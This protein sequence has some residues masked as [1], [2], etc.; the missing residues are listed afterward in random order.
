[1]SLVPRAR[2]PRL[3]TRL[4]TAL[5]VAAA[6]GAIGAASSS[7]AAPATCNPF[8]SF[9]ASSFA[10]RPVID[11]ALFPL[12]PGSRFVLEGHSAVTGAVLP[13]TI[14]FI[15]SD[16]TKV[17]A[18]VRTLVGWDVDRDAGQLA[19]SELAFFA[20]DGTGNVW[21]LGEYPEEYVKGKFSGAPSTW[22]HGQNNAMAGVL[23][24]GHPSPSDPEW[25]QGS[26]PD[27]AF[28]DCAVVSRTE[29][30]TCVPVGCFSNVTVVD[31]RSPLDPAS[32]TQ[33]KFY[34][35]GVGN[36][37]VTAIGDP[38]AETL[39]LAQTSTLSDAELAD[40]RTEVLKLDAHGR[41]VS[42]IY[43]T[44]PPIEQL[45][46]L[47]PPPPP[48]PPAPE[49]PAT[50]EPGPVTTPPAQVAQSAPGGTLDPSAYVAKIDNPLFPVSSL[51]RTVAEGIERDPDSG[52]S[53]KVRV[54]ARL[55]AAPT[56]VGRVPATTVDV[57]EY[58]NGKLVE[59][60]HDLYAQDHDG[61]VWYLGEDV[62]EIRNGKIVGHEGQWRA[63]RGDA[64][65]GLFM[66]AA[67]RV[68]QTFQQER[69]PRIA[70][71]RSTVLARGLRVTTAAGRFSGCMKVRDVAPLDHLTQT[72]YYCRGAGLVREAAKGTRIDLVRVTRVGR[73]S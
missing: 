63:G 73:G 58:E 33:E 22:F 69:A 3:I 4:L 20:Q 71:D 51:R 43:A 9:S 59:H 67:P 56:M 42:T 54:V 36:V 7:A 37:Q 48:P 21:T 34:A 50:T 16:E 44:T 57:R 65:P 32:G 26:S 60:T 31:E 10:D 19:E 39:V 5:A 25:L 40:A 15:V 12:K 14:T 38:E 35:P 8:T 24:P 30:S 61:N 62:D 68:G 45:A 41:Q 27:I 53:P 64:K 23:V 29:P 2:S 18:G 49:P 1:M 55:L 11:N 72:K 70:E 66:P 46:P 28:L 17:I 52:K 47:P 13:H 6:T